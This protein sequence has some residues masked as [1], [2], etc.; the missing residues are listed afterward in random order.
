MIGGSDFLFQF[1]K[2]PVFIFI[3]LCVM[4]LS[5]GLVTIPVMPEM[6]EA[7]EDDAELSQKYDMEQVANFISGLF[8]TYQ[9]M[10]EAIG[11]IISSSIA[12]WYNF[13]AS[14]EF[15]AIVLFMFSFFYF[16]MCGNFSMFGG[17]SRLRVSRIMEG[18]DL[19]L[20]ENE[21]HLSNRSA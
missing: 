18:E 13:T 10:G 20:I 5:A 14:Q 8:V 17:D 6:L 12:E 3:G 15:F 9:S 4:G 2:Q 16:S 7:I 21:N 19:S 11:P 1:Q